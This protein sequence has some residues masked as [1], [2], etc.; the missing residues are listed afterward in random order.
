MDGDPWIWPIILQII[1]IALN[2]VFACAEIAV[3]S[4]NDTKLEK[5]AAEGDKRAGNA[6]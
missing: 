1:L 3:I 4:M 5:L 2:A 6:F